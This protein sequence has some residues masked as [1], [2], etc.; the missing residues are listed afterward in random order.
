MKD[1]M[2]KGLKIGKNTSKAIKQIRNAKKS[3]KRFE[4]KAPYIACECCGYNVD[5]IGDI[6][7]RC[8]WEQVG[9]DVKT[10]AN[11]V[12]LETYQIL[13]LSYGL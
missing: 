4:I 7:H 5:G 12:S 11:P 6:C 3:F 8:G 13:F 9:T 10:G 1:R 2:P